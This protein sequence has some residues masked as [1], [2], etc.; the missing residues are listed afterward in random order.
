[1]SLSRP[2]RDA[3]WSAIR[4]TRPEPDEVRVYDYP[5]LSVEVLKWERWRG[6]TCYISI[7]TPAGLEHGTHVDEYVLALNPDVADAGWVLAALAGL[8]AERR[9]R[10]SN[11]SVVSFDAPLWDGAGASSVLLLTSYDKRDHMI[12]MPDGRHLSL[13]SVL[14]LFHEEIEVVRTNGH[15]ALLSAWE[16]KDVACWDPFRDSSVPARG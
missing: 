5:H 7:G 15:E 2:E 16:S 10:V 3:R 4:A 12:P 8:R 14:P 9:G 13:L 11:G 6:V 1:M